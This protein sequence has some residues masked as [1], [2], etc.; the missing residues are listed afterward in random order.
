[1][2]DTSGHKTSTFKDVTEPNLLQD[3]FP[4]VEPPHVVFDGPLL[5]Q[6]D[7][8]TVVMHPAELRT[9]DIHITDP[10]FRDGQQARPP[11]TVAQTAELFDLLSRLSGPHGVIRQTEFF[12]YSPKDRAAVAVPL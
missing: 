11:Y 2:H 1:M 8:E 9:R 12:I 7:G 10:T 4:H 6:F 3:V 5:E